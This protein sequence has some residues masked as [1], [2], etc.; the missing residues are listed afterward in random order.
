MANPRYD[1]LPLLRFLEMYVLNAI[2][3]LPPEQAQALEEMAPRL[4]ALYG[5]DGT[6]LSAIETS[7]QAPPDLP[8]AIREMWARNQAI[9]RQ[10]DTILEPQKFAEMFVDANLRPN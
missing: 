5:G 8:D 2:A 7:I 1:G 3:E 4:H 10:H 9:A 6:W